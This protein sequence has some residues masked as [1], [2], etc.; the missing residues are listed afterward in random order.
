M[1]SRAG[2]RLARHRRAARGAHP[3]CAARRPRSAW[4]SSPGRSARR[5][6]ARPALGAVWGILTAIS[7]CSCCCCARPTATSGARRAVLKATAVAAAH[8]RVA[9]VFIRDLDLLPAGEALAWLVTLAL[10]SRVLGRLLISISLPRLAGG[11]H[12]DAAHAPAALLRVAR[13]RAPR[14]GAERIQFLGAAL[15]LTGLL[16][17]SLRRSR[18][19]ARAVKRIRLLLPCVLLVLCVP[20]DA[21]AATV[22]VRPRPG[23][24]A[25]G[26]TIFYEAGGARAQPA[27]G[28]AVGPRYVLPQRGRSGQR[29]PT[30]SALGRTPHP[31]ARR[32]RRRVRR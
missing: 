2:D 6:R 16:M 15:I 20:G 25:A 29:R 32:S 8:S 31:S 23:R 22:V 26:N 11:A 10:T 24:E 5:V 14:R 9:G 27:D 21:G 19:T 1:V 13:R 3:R 17:V 12:V 4:C 30:R 7:F 28:V 18:D